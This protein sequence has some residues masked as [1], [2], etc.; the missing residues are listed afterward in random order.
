MARD[1]VGKS[2]PVRRPPAVLRRHAWIGLGAAAVVAFGGLLVVAA[3]R[4]VPPRV[5]DHIHARY[6]VVICGQ[7]HP[8]FPFT[9]GNVHTHG[10]GVIHVHPANAGEAGRNANLARFFESAGVKFSRD[11][12]VFPD[13]KAYRNGDRCPDGSIGTV[14]L[15][16]NGEPSDA[17]ERY[18]PRDG[19]TIVVEFQ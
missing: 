9:P 16:M 1:R 4:P 10:D 3:T 6:G 11:W 19:D 17:F 13:G 18:V 14:R 7:L 12:I 2:Y 15:V 8:Q 5:G